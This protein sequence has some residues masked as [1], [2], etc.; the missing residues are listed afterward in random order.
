MDIEDTLTEITDQPENN[1]EK[2]T[3]KKATEKQLIALAAAREKRKTKP[4]ALVPK[5]TPAPAPAPEPEPVA[6]VIVKKVKAKKVVAKP[7]IIQIDSSD[8]DSADEAPPTIVIRRSKSKVA[9]I[10]VAPKPEPPRQYIRR[11]Y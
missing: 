7:T 3:K 10:P 6:D 9:Q 2:P 4:N 11:A 1:I 5:P 8:S